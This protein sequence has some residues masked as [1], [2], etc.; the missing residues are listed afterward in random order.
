MDWMKRSRARV[1][2]AACV[3]FVVMETT[4][5]F[6]Y[7]DS[8][9]IRS[10]SS[11]NYTIY[12]RYTGGKVSIGTSNAPGTNSALQVNGGAAIGYNASTNVPA[13]GLA[14]GGN[15]GIGTTS[16][17]SLLDV[18]GTININDG[19]AKVSSIVPNVQITGSPRTLRFLNSSSDDREGFQFYSGN[20][21]SSI[22]AVLNSGNV[23]IG[24]TSP[25]TLLEV[26]GN[27][28]TIRISDAVN[29]LPQLEFLRGTGAF[30]SDAYTDWRL[31]VTGGNFRFLRQD[32]AGN[33]GD[34]V[35]ILTNG[36]V[37]I[38]TTNPGSYKLAVKGKIAAQEV[39]VTQNGWSD[40]VF[41][42]NYRL[43]PLNKVAEYVKQ[44]KHLEGIPTAAEVKKNGVSVGDMQAKLLEKVEELTL[45]TIAM[46]KD[47]EAMQKENGE[48]RTRISELERN[49]KR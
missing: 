45:Y 6:G 35:T 43:Q 23:G 49:A 40:F 19:S 36:N 16:P 12:N 30:G 22:M 41:N 4:T 31:Y 10:G 27:T 7:S 38:G 20:H 21:S 37:G 3:A 47:C 15:V 11:P 24:T 1:I 32:N 13:N 34:A 48:L 28:P 5:V 39:V 33:S 17:L 42:E 46:K 26:A 2:V 9:W 14:V 18:A 29:N 25:N 8:L 44:N